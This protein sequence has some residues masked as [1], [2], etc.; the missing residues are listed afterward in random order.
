MASIR[1]VSASEE[2]AAHAEISSPYPQTKKREHVAAPR[3]RRIVTEGFPKKDQM[4]CKFSVADD[5]CV[6]PKHLH[7]DRHAIYHNTI[8]LKCMKKIEEKSRQGFKQRISRVDSLK[9]RLHQHQQHARSS[10]FCPMNED[11]GNKAVLHSAEEMKLA[12]HIAIGILEA[13]QLR[14]VN[15]LAINFLE[16]EQKRRKAKN[17][18]PPPKKR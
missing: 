15:D 13:E 4:V 3:V 10:E 18:H 9:Q 11:S 8:K 12:A 16:E 14:R 17:A 1:A 5:G 2:H 6:C 7:E